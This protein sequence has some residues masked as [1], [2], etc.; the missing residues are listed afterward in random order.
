MD[1]ETEKAVRENWA[2]M[3]MARGHVAEA[4]QKAQEQAVNPNIKEEGREKGR[5]RIKALAAI[6]PHVQDIPITQEGATQARVQRTRQA[7]ARAKKIGPLTDPQTGWKM[8]EVPEGSGWYFSHHADIASAGDQHGFSR[9]QAITV[10]TNMS[11]E[12]HPEIEKRAGRAIMNMVAGQDDHTVHVTPELHSVVNQRLKGSDLQGAPMP[13]N[14]KGQH[15]KLS[16]M[17]AKHIAAI[18]SVAAHMR[19]EKQQPVQSTAPFEDLGAARKAKNAFKGIE[20]LRGQRSLEDVIDPH[21]APKLWSYRQ[22]TLDSV[23]GSA[24]HLEYMARAQDYQRGGQKGVAQGRRTPQGFHTETPEERSGRQVE[25]MRSTLASVEAGKKYG[26]GSPEHRLA[27]FTSLG[28]RAASTIRQQPSGQYTLPDPRPLRQSDEGILAKDRPTAEDTWMQ[29]ISTQQDPRSVR[30]GGEPGEA[31]G[32]SG[33]SIAKTLVS[34]PDLASDKRMRKSSVSSEAKVAT[35]G[36][37]KNAALRH[38]VENHATRQAAHQIGMPATFTQEV[39][40]SEQR[41]RAD[42]SPEYRKQLGIEMNLRSL[43]KQPPPLGRQYPNAPRNPVTPIHHAAA[44][45]LYDRVV[46]GGSVSQH[47]IEHVEQQRRNAG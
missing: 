42:K 10:T 26:L 2:A 47:E 4:K 7:R 17:D 21:S 41:I 12:N 46:G 18:G 16:D 23:P 37:V 15:V 33:S 3:G 44:K 43:P 20:Y 39:P 6:E 11:P 22:N 34:D 30:E 38:A 8:P 40:W 36:R 31:K 29:S 9:E 28:Q 19:E 35:D 24:A 1:P 45:A 25:S 32:R 5:K 14:W 13:A 27:S